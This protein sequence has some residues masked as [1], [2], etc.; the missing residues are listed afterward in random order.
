MQHCRH[1]SPGWVQRKGAATG[2]ANRS[3]GGCGQQAHAQGRGRA[4][5]RTHAHAYARTHAKS[6]PPPPYT[7]NRSRN[8][9][10]ADMHSSTQS[11]AHA[12]APSTNSKP[13]TSTCC[14][15]PHLDRRQLPASPN[16]RK[17]LPHPRPGSAPPVVV[18]AACRT[19][20]APSHT[21]AA[22][23]RPPNAAVTKP[24]GGRN[25]GMG[26][27]VSKETQRQLRVT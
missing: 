3:T 6:P 26:P 2:R 10:R 7:G 13:P 17:G 8:T 15:G 14:F 27:L 20:S 4:R 23:P 18:H 21:A 16:G 19:R 11:Q 24:A 12:S 1:S 22:A 25:G 9:M 5:A